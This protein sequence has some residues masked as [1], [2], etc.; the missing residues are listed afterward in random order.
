MDF[1]ND[2]F[3]LQLNSNKCHLLT[4]EFIP[5]HTADAAS[6][7]HVKEE[8]PQEFGNL[9]EPGTSNFC[10]IKQEIKTENESSSDSDGFSDSNCNYTGYNSEDSHNMKDFDEDYVADMFAPDNKKYNY[11]DP[12]FLPE[13][14]K[15]KKFLIK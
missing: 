2:C 11:L 7:T 12:N 6:E 9:S 5:L 15:S 1:C 3:I 4:H 13:L 10:N 14:Y 8:F